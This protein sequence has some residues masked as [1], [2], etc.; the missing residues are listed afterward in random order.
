MEFAL[1]N[2][3]PV[4]MEGWEEDYLKAADSRADKQVAAGIPGML[5]A[6]RMARVSTG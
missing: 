2:C 5:L 4:E 6:L 1:H 3:L